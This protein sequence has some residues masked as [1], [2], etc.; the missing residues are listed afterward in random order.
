MAAIRL[1]NK[2]GVSSDAVDRQAQK[3]RNIR[4][5]YETNIRGKFGM[6]GRMAPYMNGDFTTGPSDKYRYDPEIYNKKFRREEYT[7]KHVVPGKT[8]MDILDQT[9]SMMIDAKGNPKRQQRI[10]NTGARYLRNMTSRVGDVKELGKIKEAINDPQKGGYIR[11]RQTVT[12]DLTP[13][14]RRGYM[15]TPDFVKGNIVG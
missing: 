11:H 15:R 5:R 4:D 7:S 10:L 8:T 1:Y 9:R 14:A 12:G 2:R 3:A 13:I 6:P